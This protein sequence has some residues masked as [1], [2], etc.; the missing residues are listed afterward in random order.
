MADINW[1]PFINTN[2]RRSASKKPLITINYD[3]GRIS[4]N[5]ASCELIPDCYSYQY[6][7]VYC[8]TIDGTLKKI[9]IH[10]THNKSIKSIPLSRKK[11]KDNYTGG[12][13]FHSK[14]LVKDIYQSAPQ[15]PKTSHFL[16]D[17]QVQSGNRCLLFDIKES[18][19][20]S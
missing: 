9:R 14:A 11:Y 7:E 13:V 1:D 20:D 17:I 10:F 5:S 19:T 6:V 18:L 3:T 16:A 2:V 8:G 15:L 12:S 4:L